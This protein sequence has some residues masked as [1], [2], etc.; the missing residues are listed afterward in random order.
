MMRSVGLW[1]WLSL[2][3]FLI[4]PACAGSGATTRL[5]TVRAI[6]PEMS[7]DVYLA[8][9]LPELG[10]WRADGLLMSGD[11]G[12]R[13]ATLR[14]PS[15][16]TVE[17]KITRGRWEH[18]G[19]GPSGTVLANTRVGPESDG[20][21]TITIGGW[22]RDV[23]HYIADAPGAGVAG[24][25]L[26]WPDV[27]SAGL[28]E[29]RTVSIY[30]PPQYGAAPD[31]RFPVV[32]V[33]DGQNL[34]DPRIASTGVDWGI[35]EAMQSL[36]QE[37]AAEPA[38]VVGIWSTPARRLEY[39]PQR[40]LERITGEMAGLSEIEFPGKMRRADAY[41][42]FLAEELK[43]RVDAAFRTRP[44]RDSTFLMGS[45]M[46][47]L[48]S[49][50]TLAERPDVFGGAAG[51]SMHWPISIDEA[52]IVRREAAWR[53]AVLAAFAGYLETAPIEPATHRLWIDRG[54]GFLD[55][56]Y[57]PYQTAL[58]T[59]LARRGFAEGQSLIARVYAGADH[60]EAAWRARLRDPMRFLLG[61]NSAA[62]DRS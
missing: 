11:G 41:V 40:V 21:V 38:I 52:V 61:R 24:Q 56:L 18:E 17:F 43:P 57:E 4:V 28:E 46:G 7:G 31:D 14:V 15:L 39:A 1:A 19:L 27:K 12:A 42:R 47:G 58:T 36:V 10:P 5:I 29:P 51:L 44:D 59:V 23:S 26:Y 20:E 13:T 62:P 32:Y 30:L 33:Q 55:Y 60:N 54:T 16:S 9:S 35:D 34:L 22:K 48:I 37:G 25:L 8:G 2:C 50:Y 49:L 3:L 45:S 6:V 53:P